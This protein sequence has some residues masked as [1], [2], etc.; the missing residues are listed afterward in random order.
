MCSSS[1]SPREL[2]WQFFLSKK[3]CWSRRFSIFSIIFQ[4]FNRRFFCPFPKIK[5]QEIS[6]W[7]CEFTFRNFFD[8]KSCWELKFGKTLSFSKMV[9]LENDRNFHGRVNGAADSWGISR[10]LITLRAETLKKK[11]WLRINYVDNLVN[12][13]LS[14]FFKKSWA[15]SLISVFKSC[16]FWPNHKNRLCLSSLSILKMFSFKFQ[17]QIPKL[18]K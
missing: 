9:V 6:I 18:W 15:E 3:S 16:V 5:P 4:T 10:F 11:K 2:N 12:Y 13:V 1:F 7:S 8:E 14:N 17:I